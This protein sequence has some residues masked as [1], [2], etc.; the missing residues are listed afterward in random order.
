MNKQEIWVKASGSYFG[1]HSY[2]FL[3]HLLL[4]LREFSMM[5]FEHCYPLPQLFP[6]PSPLFPKY[7]FIYVL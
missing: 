5:D 3:T 4:G 7:I 1:L 2:N 6:N